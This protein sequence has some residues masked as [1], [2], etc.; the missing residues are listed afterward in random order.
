[1]RWLVSRRWWILAGIFALLLL[2]LVQSWT[3]LSY[4]P[5]E[6]L[7]FFLFF[8]LVAL[9]AGRWAPRRPGPH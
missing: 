9:V 5:L 8:S 7:L 2:G 6:A 4:I 3:F 1:M